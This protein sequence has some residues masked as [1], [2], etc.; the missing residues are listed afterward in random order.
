M[1]TA[2]QIAI[3]A[4]RLANRANVRAI[5]ALLVTQGPITPMIRRL[6]PGSS[7]QERIVAVIT[8]AGGECSERD[9][10]RSGSGGSGLKIQECKET[11]C[12]MV[13]DGTITVRKSKPQGGGRPSFIYAVG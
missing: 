9:I 5:K 8:N 3:D 7:I 6:P 13:E 2:I 12:W 1:D 4:L 11:L 10:Y